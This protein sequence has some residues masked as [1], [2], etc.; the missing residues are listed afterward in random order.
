MAMQGNRNQEAPENAPDE[1]DDQRN[2]SD[3]QSETR[4]MPMPDSGR[5]PVIKN[6]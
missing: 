5:E 2:D 4:R 1:Q 3:Q 6:T